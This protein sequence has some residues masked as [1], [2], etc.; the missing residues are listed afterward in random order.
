M[1]VGM[2][3]YRV[4][5][6]SN[7]LQWRLSPDLKRSKATT[8]GKPFLMGGKTLESIEKP[9]LGRRIIVPTRD[10]PSCAEGVNVV[11]LVEEA[12]ALTRESPEPPGHQMPPH[13]V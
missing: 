10:F 3:S 12:P 2:A 8:L 11:W 13:A 9:L 7:T 5:G 1:V 4:I 6:R